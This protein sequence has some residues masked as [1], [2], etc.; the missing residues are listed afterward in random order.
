MYSSSTKIEYATDITLRRIV[1]LK[2]Y[3]MQR[4]KGA[5]S[6]V[7]AGAS[8]ACRLVTF[9][10]TFGYCLLGILRLVS[11]IKIMKNYTNSKMTEM[12]KMVLITDVHMVLN[13]SFVSRKVSGAP[14]FYK[15]VWTG[16]KNLRH[17]C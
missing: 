12:G 8:T 5:K 7:I 14:F 17:G 9:S 10:A 3:R 11:L 6:F 2:S 4:K 1:R 16:A 15:G 13:T